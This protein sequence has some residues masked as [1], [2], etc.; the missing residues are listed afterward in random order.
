VFQGCFKAILVQK[1]AYLLEVARY[2]ALNP[3]R[4]RIVRIA[5]AWRWSSYRVT[6]GY[7]ENAACLTTEWILAGIT[8]QYEN[9]EVKKRFSIGRSYPL[10][11]KVCS[12]P[13]RDISLLISSVK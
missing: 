9:F 2:I 10:M 8:A 7:E 5:K 12:A 11:K 4:A 13:E 1:D 3:V 6:A